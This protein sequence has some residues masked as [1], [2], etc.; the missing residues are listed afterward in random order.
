MTSFSAMEISRIKRY[1]NPQV[2][3]DLDQFLDN[4]PIRAGLAPLIGAATIWIIAALAILFSY[5]KVTELVELQQE[6][7]KTEAL[8]PSVPTITFLKID[9]KTIEPIV[10]KIDQ[11]YRGAQ[12][13]MLR[14]GT[15]EVKANT[16][17]QFP[18]WRAAIDALTYANRSWRLKFE[19]LCTG[20]ECEGSPLQA[21]V[22]LESIDIK[23]PE[24]Q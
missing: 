6:L 9:N 4:L 19:E 10:E 16:T 8:R 7:L 11:L 15:I 20:R 14:D 5:T 21:K 17:A 2:L 3:K 23:V 22:K 12:V 24:L 13:K 18:Q 1:L